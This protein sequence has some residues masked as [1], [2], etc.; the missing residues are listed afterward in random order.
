MDEHRMGLQPIH[1]RQW[2]RKEQKTKSTHYGYSW[3][4]DYAFVE[5]KTGKN[6]HF[7]FSHLNG[8]RPVEDVCK[9]D[10]AED[11]GFFS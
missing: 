4:W 7:F 6:H 5:P 2:V 10:R 3:L 8:T 1:R 9:K 11:R